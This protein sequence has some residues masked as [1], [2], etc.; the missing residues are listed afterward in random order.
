MTS[1]SPAPRSRSLTPRPI[2]TAQALLSGLA[3]VATGDGGFRI[4]LEPNQSLP[5]AAGTGD[6]SGDGLADVII[7]VA[8]AN[9]NGA[10]S[11]RSY[12]VFGKADGATVELVDVVLGNGGYVVNGE[13]VSDGSGIAVAGTGDVNGDGFLDFIVGASEA[14]PNG[15]SSGRGY[16]LFGVPTGSG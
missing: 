6:V 5:F 16:L 9:P 10:N 3:D 15:A 11:G 13:G 4:A 2:R 14:D 1:S 7:G 12:I 8:S